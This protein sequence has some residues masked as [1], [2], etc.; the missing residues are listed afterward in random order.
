LNSELQVGTAL[1]ADWV[2]PARSGFTIEK[3]LFKNQAALYHDRTRPPQ[4]NSTLDSRRLWLALERLV[5][6]READ[7]SPRLPQKASTTVLQD[8]CALVAHAL[9]RAAST[10]MWTHG[11][12]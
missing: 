4:W 9:M 3:N 6:E 12:G 10:L 7:R 1:P 2:R 11:V 8:P 5:L